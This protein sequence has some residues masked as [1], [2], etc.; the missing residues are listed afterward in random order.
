MRSTSNGFKLSARTGSRSWRRRYTEVW[1]GCQ[2]N[3]LEMLFDRDVS[4]ALSSLLGIA[5]LIVGFVV[6][7]VIICRGT[8]CQRGPGLVLTRNALEVRRT[9]GA[10]RPVPGFVSRRSRNPAFERDGTRRNPGRRL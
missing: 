6:R 2:P 7:I 10:D 3:G 5:G 4:G 9:L 1:R 8:I